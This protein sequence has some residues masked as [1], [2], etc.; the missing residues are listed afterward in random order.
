MTETSQV[1]RSDA[2]AADRPKPTVTQAP[3]R[4]RGRLLVIAAIAVVVAAALVVA[5]VLFFGRSSTSPSAKSNAQTASAALSAGLTAQTKGD[6]AAATVQFNKVLQ[7][8]KT[9]KYAIYDLAL[10][11]SAHSDYGQAEAK[12]RQALAVD[13][14]YE[15]ALFNLA[16]LVQAK[17]DNKGAIVLYQRAVKAAPKDAS[18]H[19]N[20][21]LL[22][23]SSGQKAAGNKE[24]KVA[25]TLNPKLVDPARQAA[26]PTPAAKQAPS[27]TSTH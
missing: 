11:D 6:L 2:S 14:T 21:G 27:G 3:R 17:N 24:V 5:G 13:P 19:L 26:K 25:T 16:I 4:R 7:Y 8:D 10:I 1:E 20:L 15:P 18:A 12:Y 22:L 23:R 9:N